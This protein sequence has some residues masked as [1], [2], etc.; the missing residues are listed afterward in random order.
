MKDRLEFR[1]TVATGRIETGFLKVLTKK[2][3]PYVDRLAEAIVKFV[4]KRS[5]KEIKDLEK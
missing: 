1:F 4:E 2:V 5:E 3:E